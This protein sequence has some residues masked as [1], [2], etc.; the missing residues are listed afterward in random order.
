MK[1]KIFMGVRYRHFISL[2]LALLI[3]FFYLYWDKPWFISDLISLCIMGSSVKLFKLVSIK[4][5]I[6]FFLPVI[7][8]DIVALI[9]VI[10]TVR[11]VKKK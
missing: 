8:F 3:M 9:Y 11:Y 7:L 4:D 1:T 10:Y 6:R 2:P 5:S